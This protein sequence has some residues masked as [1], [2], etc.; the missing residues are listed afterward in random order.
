MPQV[1][2]RAVPEVAPEVRPLPTFQARGAEE[3]AFGGGIGA[4]QREYGGQVIGYGGQL[5]EKGKEIARLGGAEEGVGEKLAQSAIAFQQL[6]NETWAKDND[7]KV[8]TE[9]GQAKAEYDKLEGQNAVNA[10]PGFQE[11]IKGI[12]EKYLATAPN[13]EAKSMLDNSMARQVGYA[14]VDAGARAGNQAKIAADRASKARL[15]AYVDAI[16]LH[17]PNAVRSNLKNIR[18]ES[19]AQCEHR[20]DEADTCQLSI[21]HNTGRAIGKGI[22]DIAYSDPDLARKS[23]EEY[24]NFMEPD[25][26]EQAHTAVLRGEAGTG[27]LLAAQ[28]ATRDFDPSKGPGQ[29]EEMLERGKKATEGSEN[30]YLK[31]NTESRIRGIV[32]LG[33]SGYRDTQ[34]ASLNK[35]ENFIIGSSDEKRIVNMDALRNDP[36]MSSTFDSLSAQNQKVALDFM[37]KTKRLYEKSTPEQDNNFD[38][39]YGMSRSNSTKE[40]FVGLN[41]LGENLTYKQVQLLEKRKDA[42]LAKSDPDEDVDRYYSSVRGRVRNAGISHDSDEELAFKGKFSQALNRFKEAHPGKTPNY[43]ELNE[44]ATDLLLNQPGGPGKGFLH[45]AGTPRYELDIPDDQYQK[46][47]AALRAEG[48]PDTVANIYNQYFKAKAA[49]K[50]K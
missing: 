13:A 9:I 46:L 14:I 3:T 18:E 8:L 17:N 4:A 31:E 47:G 39:L 24:K 34:I 41:L 16:D 12:R 22:K 7:V 29:L 28:R 26:R 38:R 27:S 49:G 33:L 20:G 40:Q 48:I 1:P 5:R 44:I 25:T 6:N 37:A 15:D 23:Y 42:L 19:I 32:N 10:L 50:V 45:L 11:Q 36:E 43:K 35:V 21:K 2:Y 30:P